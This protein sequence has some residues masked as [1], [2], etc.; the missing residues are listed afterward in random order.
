MLYHVPDLSR[1]LS[2]IRRILKPGGM[3]YTTTTGATGVSEAGRKMMEASL[4]SSSFSLENGEQQL[5][6]CFSHVELYRL[7]QSLRIAE[8]ELFCSLIAKS[9]E[10]EQ[11]RQYMRS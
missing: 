1:T 5:S 4:A 9:G 3:F 8:A 2:E 10:E 6:R 7:E 11:T